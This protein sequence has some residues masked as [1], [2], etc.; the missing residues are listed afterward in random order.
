M[1]MPGKQNNHHTKILSKGN[2]YV[3]EVV[4]SD[5]A[6]EFSTNRNILKPLTIAAEIVN[7]SYPS[8]RNYEFR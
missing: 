8:G 3:H 2:F 5:C 6:A 1:R 7:G 4:C